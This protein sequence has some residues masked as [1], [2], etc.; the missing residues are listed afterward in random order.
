MDYVS[1]EFAGLPFD[2]L[3]CLAEIDGPGILATAENVPDRQGHVAVS[4]K[5]LGD[6]PEGLGGVGIVE[7]LGVDIF[8]A[9][10]GIAELFVACLVFYGPVESVGSDGRTGG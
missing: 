4:G 3:Q 6:E 7:V 10:P 2:I 9:I 1:P 8:S 5:L